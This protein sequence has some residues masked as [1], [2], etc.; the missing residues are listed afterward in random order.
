[1]ISME[2]NDR[3]V[4]DAPIARRMVRLAVA[5]VPLLISVG[6]N[7]ASFDC[8]RAYS[9]VEKLI[10]ST[11]ALSDLDSQLQDV[12]TRAQARAQDGDTVRS[13]QRAWRNNVRDACQDEVCLTDAYNNRIASVRATLSELTNS[14][15]A[16]SPARQALHAAAA[17]KAPTS[18]SNAIA[19]VAGAEGKN[20]AE[21]DKVNANKDIRKTEQQADGASAPV[22]VA[23]VPV[24][25]VSTPVDAASTPLDTV[26]APVAQEGKKAEKQTIGNPVTVQKDSVPAPSEGNDSHIT[27]RVTWGLGF[28]FVA[29]LTAVAVRA[30]QGGRKSIDTIKSFSQKSAPYI[31]APLSFAWACLK[32]YI[33]LFKRGA[34]SLWLTMSGSLIALIWVCSH[35]ASVPAGEGTTKDGHPRITMSEFAGQMLSSRWESNGEGAVYWGWH[36]LCKPGVPSQVEIGMFTYDLIEFDKSCFV[37]APGPAFVYLDRKFARAGDIVEVSFGTGDDRKKFTR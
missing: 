6:A 36:N 35:F 37:D 28:L 12:Y 10:C 34:V 31:A 9:R 33:S 14:Q 25:V 27:K 19:E 16:R 1:M 22:D 20:V 3:I 17:V 8:A 13:D 30:R 21:A 2:A 23:S 32:F 29:L 15:S 5:L 24:A 11:G 7:A 4:N 18:E 26:S